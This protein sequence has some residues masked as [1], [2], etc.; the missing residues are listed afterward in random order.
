M[1]LSHVGRFPG[2]TTASTTAMMMTSASSQQ[3][4]LRALVEETLLTPPRAFAG[5]VALVPDDDDGTDGSSGGSAYDLAVAGCRANN[6]CSPQRPAAVLV[7]SCVEDVRAAVLCAAERFYL[8]SSTKILLSR[9]MC[10]NAPCA[11]RLTKVAR[12]L[13]HRPRPRHPHRRRHP[14]PLLAAACP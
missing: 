9:S 3:L 8:I 2:V 11:H 6:N 1:L 7:P 5:E 4:L 14:W 10:A 13:T 12:S